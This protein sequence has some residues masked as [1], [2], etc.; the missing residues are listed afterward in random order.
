MGSEASSFPRFLLEMLKS[1]FSPHGDL[2]IL[3]AA[4]ATVGVM[5]RILAV[6]REI[7]E[8]MEKMPDNPDWAETDRRRLNKWYTMFLTLISI[9]PL[10]GM[11][12]TVAALLNL[13]FSDLAGSLDSVKTDF[14]RALT[15]TA[16]G[17][18]FSVTFKLINSW[19]FFDVED[20]Y[21]E[22]DDI[23]RT[24]RR[25]EEPEKPE[26]P[27]PRRSRAGF[28]KKLAKKLREPDED[29]FYDGEG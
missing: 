6:R 10:L 9:F 20:I 16:W 14:F 12:G 7:I 1:I 3:F 22:I 24:N 4:A 15:S 18:V 19:F 21:A 29:D 23:V 13:D 28:A 11:F 2:Y 8:E 17:I 5:L 25:G 26:A 27:A